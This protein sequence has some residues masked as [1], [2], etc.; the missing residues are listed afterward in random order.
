MGHLDNFRNMFSSFGKSYIEQ[1][2]ISQIQPG[3]LVNPMS[4]SRQ[5]DKYNLQLQQILNQVYENISNQI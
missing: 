4:S 5:F 2:I 1:Q 3:A